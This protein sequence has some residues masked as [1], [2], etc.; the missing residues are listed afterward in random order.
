MCGIVERKNVSR[1]KENRSG[2]MDVDKEG[3]NNHY[4][5][6]NLEQTK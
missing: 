4:G 1:A 3:S 6:K 2:V 5:L